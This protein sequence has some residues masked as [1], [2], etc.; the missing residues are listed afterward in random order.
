VIAFTEPPRD[1][2]VEKILRP[3]RLWHAS[4]SR[5]PPAEDGLASDPDDAPN[6]Q[7]AS[8]DQPWK[9]TPGHGHVPGHLVIIT[10]GRRNGAELNAPS[11]SGGCTCNDTPVSQAFVSASVIEHSW[12]GQ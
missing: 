6:S 8:F 7:T 10:H 4:T 9:Q 12:I 2:L 5:A 1:D 3:C 11:M